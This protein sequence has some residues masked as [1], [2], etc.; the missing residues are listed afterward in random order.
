MSLKKSRR[1]QLEL[2]GSAIPAHSTR[3]YDGKIE[4]Q[5]ADRRKE[6]HGG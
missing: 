4:I 5:I 3:Q 1:A 6:K 2:E